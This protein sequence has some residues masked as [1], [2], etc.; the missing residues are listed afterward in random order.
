MSRPD[1]PSALC[2][3]LVALAEG[4]L[5]GDGSTPVLGTLARLPGVRIFTQQ[6]DQWRRIQLTNALITTLR[7][8]QDPVRD[9]DLVQRAVNVVGTTAIAEKRTSPRLA[10]FLAQCNAVIERVHKNEYAGASTDIVPRDDTKP[11][12]PPAP[13][14]PTPAPSPKAVSSPV[15]SRPLPPS[16]NGAVAGKDSPESI[17]RVAVAKPVVVTDEMFT[18]EGVAAYQAKNLYDRLGVSATA[19]HRELRAAF[20]RLEK[21]LSADKNPT[22]PKEQADTLFGSLCEAYQTLK[23]PMSRLA[24]DTALAKRDTEDSYVPHTPASPAAPLDPEQFND[25]GPRIKQAVTNLVPKTQQGRLLAGVGLFAAVAAVIV[26]GRSSG[27]KP[28]SFRP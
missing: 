22:R 19:T 25:F 11:A 27:A 26:A 5:K 7:A 9:I 14:L 17:T 23:N 3:E 16:P 15:A 6:P 8:L 12:P 13:K 1:K 24:Y 18:P 21:Q 28:S 2:D 20:L 4:Y 10:A